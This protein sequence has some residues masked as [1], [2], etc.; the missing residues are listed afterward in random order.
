LRQTKPRNGAAWPRRRTGWV[1]VEME[2]R[3]LRIN[4]LSCVRALTGLEEGVMPQDAPN[5]PPPEKIEVIARR[6]T[7]PIVRRDIDTP[8]V[9]TR[10]FRLW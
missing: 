1:A 3:V 5:N 8:K 9:K 4:R 10:N 2:E 7:L 6:L